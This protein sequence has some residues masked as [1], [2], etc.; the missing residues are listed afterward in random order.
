ME[1]LVLFS[2]IIIVFTFLFA[3]V[4]NQRGLQLESQTF[5]S[6]ELTAQSIATQLSI[7][8]TSGSGYSAQVP[9]SGYAGSIQ[10]NISV[11]KQGIVRVSAV[12]GPQTLQAIA[13][14]SARNIISNQS[15]SNINGVYNL[16][17]SNGTVAI[18][19][20]AGDVCVDYSCQYLI[21]EAKTS[22]IR[23]TATSLKAAYFNG[24]S[25]TIVGNDNL[26]NTLSGGYNTVSFWMKWNE[27]NAA[28]PFDFVSYA[29]YLGATCT[30]FNGGAGDVYGFNPYGSLDGKWVFVTAVFYNGAYTGNSQIYINGVKQNLG[31]CLGS[32]Q[33]PVSSNEF[34]ISG[35]HWSSAYIFNGTIANVQIYNTSISSSDIQTL[36]AEG[37]GGAPIDR[38]NLA[39]WWPLNG[40]T[41][42]Y[43]GHGNNGQT[44]GPVYFNS[45][46]QISAATL[47]QFGTTT[48][49]LVGFQVNS[50]GGTNGMYLGQN[51]YYSAPTTQQTPNPLAIFNLNDISSGLVRVVASATSSQIANLSVNSIQGG[52]YNPSFVSSLKAWWPLNMGQGN[53]VYDLSGNNNTG[54]MYNVSWAAPNYAIQFDGPSSSIGVTASN[55]LDTA[56]NG[57]SW[58]IS[59]WVNERSPIATGT[60]TSRAM[61]QVA[62]GC[63]SGLWYVSS[64]NPGEYLP[65]TVEWTTTSV[66]CAPSPADLVEGGPPAPFNTWVFFTAAF[67]YSTQ[68]IYSC[69]NAVCNTKTG[70]ALGADYASISAPFVI[71]NSAIC[72]SG[73]E[74]NASMANVQL[75]NT[76]L[77]ENQIYTLYQDGISASPVSANAVGWWPLNG[78]SNDYSGNGN[79]GVISG[80]VSYVS[81]PKQSNN[82]TNVFTASFNGVSSHMAARQYSSSLN[83]RKFTVSFWADVLGSQGTWR[84]PISS[85]GYSSGTVFGYNFYAGLNNE[86][87]FWI[88]PGSGSWTVTDG[89]PVQ[90]GQWIHLVGTYNG[91]TMD[92]YNNGQLVGSTAT[93]FG[94]N[95]NS[96]CTFTIGSLNACDSYNWPFNGLISNVQVYNTS[97]STKQVQNL[98]NEGIDGLPVQD[99]NLVGWWLLDGSG[100]S[101]SGSTNLVASN[102]VYQPTPIQS[103]SALESSL[104]GYG[105]YFS[106]AYNP[107]SWATSYIETSNVPMIKGNT[108]SVFAWVDPTG[109]NNAECGGGMYCPTLITNPTGY[110]QLGLI[111]TTTFNVR[112]CLSVG[113]ITST[114][115]I[116]QDTWS[117]IGFTY[118]G[119]DTNIYINGA[120]DSIHP[121]TGS[122]TPTPGPILLGAYLSYT[123]GCP[124]P[125]DQYQGYMADVQIYNTSLSSAQVLQLY[126]NGVPPTA[127]TT[128]GIG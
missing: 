51:L 115:T 83:P 93:A 98:Y 66:N 116:S 79:N 2:V 87:Q 63:S 48:N 88:G 68:T 36:Y 40:N 94:Q 38:Q 42:D 17:V 110:Y 113:C 14:S 49:S 39:G 82:D 119:I 78:N 104:D 101:F 120:L 106:G 8:Q 61:I 47:S 59:A 92:F 52:L 53:L 18:S 32:A 5:S 22:D 16:P 95:T 26:I 54:I 70:S 99:S 58:T 12:I 11:S 60:G 13:Y 105:A 65:L 19:N 15:Y 57:H 72:C 112:P 69:T 56:W 67:N 64:T 103:P 117:F 50:Y 81:L 45:Y 4:A 96:I 97:L 44:S 20:Y 127:S 3:T 1:F 73:T 76:A 23:L 108:L 80:P 6:M 27:V 46:A 114:K 121:Q 9:V 29:F 28:M 41:N 84:S 124:F 30:G 122:L 62:T 34:Y 21:S 7:A 89:D 86:W 43:S 85:R 33:S 123:N 24:Q 128:V 75:Y 77:S 90:I 102:V 37:I 111:G 118:N 107:P 10:Y 25:G 109:S 74:L 91:S 55:T 125:C 31:Q 71:Q 35:W 100:N 126:N